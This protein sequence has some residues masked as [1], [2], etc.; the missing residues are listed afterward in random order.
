MKGSADMCF[1]KQPYLDKKKC[2]N[3]SPY[4]NIRHEERTMGIDTASFSP[5]PSLKTSL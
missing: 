2:N 1:N 4:E 5:S 3:I